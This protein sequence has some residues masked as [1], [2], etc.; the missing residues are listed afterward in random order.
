MCGRFG[1]GLVL[2][3]GAPG[4]GG[5]KGLLARRQTLEDRQRL[6]RA[7]A[8]NVEISERKARLEVVG[9]GR[10]NLQVPFCVLWTV[11]QTVEDGERPV[12]GDARRVDRECFFQRRLDVSGAL[13]GPIKIGECEPRLDL[14]GSCRHRLLE[15]GFCLFEPA[16]GVFHSAELCMGAATIRIGLHR[17]LKI[18][19]RRVEVFQR[20][21]SFASQNVRVDVFGVALQDPFRPR[22][23]VFEFTG[24]Q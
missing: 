16:A 10:Q 3:C 4:F 24:G 18:R 1:A 21:G 22:A 5:G 12:G 6:G 13:P 7:L 19:Q 2:D 8:R 20:G 11:G 9:I 17:L 23:R 15:R 14:F